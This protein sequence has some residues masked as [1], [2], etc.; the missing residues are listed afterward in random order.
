MFNA[1]GECIDNLNAQLSQLI[2]SR[3][4][5][6]FA[7]LLESAYDREGKE[8]AAVRTAVVNYLHGKRCG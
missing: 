4:L 2:S 8:D 6:V 5:L 1:A 3:V 7:E